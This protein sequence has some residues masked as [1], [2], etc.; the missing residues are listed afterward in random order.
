MCAE[1][2][3]MA[4]LQGGGAG[5]RAEEV[6][7]TCEGDVNDYRGVKASMRDPSDPIVI[8]MGGWRVRAG[9]ASEQSPR[10]FF[11]PLAGRPR[12]GRVEANAILGDVGPLYELTAAAPKSPF[13]LDVVVSPDQQE[14]VLDYAL[15]RCNVQQFP[16]GGTAVLTET[17][18]NPLASRSKTSELAFELYGFD[19]LVLGWDAG[20]AALSNSVSTGLIAHCGHSAS[21]LVPIEDGKLQL[22]GAVRSR[23][24]GHHATNYLSGLLSAE[25]ATFASLGHR[26]YLATEE[27]KHSLCY[28]ASDYRTELLK[29]QRGEIDN[30]QVRLPEHAVRLA[31]AETSSAG[32]ASGT[33]NQNDMSEQKRKALQEGA[34]RLRQVHTKQREERKRQKREWIQQLET[35]LER[36][37]RGDDS[38]LNKSGYESEESIEIALHS[39]NA[40]LARLEGKGEEHIYPLLSKDEDEMATD[41]WRRERRRQRSEKTSEDNRRKREERK[42]ENEQQKQQEEAEE[43]ARIRERP[44]E[45]VQEAQKQ[46]AELADKLRE[47]RD[48]RERRGNEQRKRQ[49]LMAEASLGEGTGDFGANEADWEVYKEMGKN[50]AADEDAEEAELESEIAQIDYKLEVAGEMLAGS[51]SAITTSSTLILGVHRIRAPEC[52]FQPHLIGRSQKGLAECASSVVRRYGSERTTHAA[53]VDSSSSGTFLCGGMA[54]MRGMKERLEYELPSQLPWMADGKEMQIN[55]AH[56]PLHDPWRGAAM[57]ASRSNLSANVPKRLTKHEYNEHGGFREDIGVVTVYR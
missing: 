24:A 38:A 6:T 11:R 21:H 27:I 55:R 35:V 37:Q 9:I 54:L 39:A 46:R 47:K 57:L 33:A 18:A 52:I 13:E 29:F 48:Q 32:S 36:V 16:A 43:E 14:M 12:G 23:T 17:L 49:R 34:E 1:C 30:R 53:Y 7:L 10:C 41:G 3:E 44:K 51:S 42:K 56:D 25:H 40:A 31:A 19:E 2:P 22:D 15:H 45:F 20:F 5:S 28:V 50:S 4:G 8:D 26:Q